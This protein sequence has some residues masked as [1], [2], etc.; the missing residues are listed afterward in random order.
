MNLSLCTI[1]FRH[2]LISLEQVVK[3]AA[4]RGFSGI[5]LWGV[6]ARNLRDRSEHDVGWLRSHGLRVPMV[7]DYLP[8]QGERQA[9]IDKTVDLCTLAHSWG[10][11][12]LRTFAG[13]KASH[14]V[15]SEERRDWTRR[16]HELC[17][18]AEDHGI[19][20]VVETHP[21]TLADTRESTRRLIEEINHPALRINFDVLHLWEAGD[22]PFEVI[23]EFEPLVAHMHLKNVRSRSLLHEFAPGNVYAPAGSRAGMVSLFE[24]AFDYRRFLTFVMTETSLWPSL[25][26]SLEWFG[27][28]VLGTLERDAELLSLLEEETLGLQTLTTAAL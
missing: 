10:A 25:D 6:H 18:L 2:H 23:R 17:E 9:M 24:G 15:S 27:P 7:S 16:M 14:E 19:N 11:S 8:V 28:N 4:P 22:D 21:A 13:N 1:S 20:L 3:W 26:A 12:K 5:E